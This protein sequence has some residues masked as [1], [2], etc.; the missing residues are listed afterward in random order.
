MKIIITITPFLI[1]FFFLY[2]QRAGNT[3][4]SN[5]GSY[6]SPIVLTFFSF[7]FIYLATYIPYLHQ[8]SEKYRVH[9]L[10]I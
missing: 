10:V 4:P 1:N 8:P 7:Y 3:I 6:I 2:F 5:V 9:F